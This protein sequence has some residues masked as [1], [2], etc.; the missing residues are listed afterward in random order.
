MQESKHYMQVRMSAGEA[1]TWEIAYK[2]VLFLG[3]GAILLAGKQTLYAGPY[4]S[5]GGLDMGDSI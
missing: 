4:V 2:D 5:W 1:W 3:H